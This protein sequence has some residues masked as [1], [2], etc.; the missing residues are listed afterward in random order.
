MFRRLTKHALGALLAVST[1]LSVVWPSVA[2]SFHNGADDP[3]CSLVIVVHDHAAHRLKE[4]PK[5]SQSPQEHC[6]IC[7][8]QSLR[9]VQAVVHLHAPASASQALAS[10]DPVHP[11]YL[12][13]TRQP[14][15]APPVEQHV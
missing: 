1:L 12:A 14:A 10:A 8:W 5:S 3:D 7:H 11:A 15:R 9:T 6:F 4:S 13:A 2:L